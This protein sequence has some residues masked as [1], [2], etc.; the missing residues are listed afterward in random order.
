LDY[1]AAMVD[2]QKGLKKEYTYDGVHPNETGYKIMA[3]L[4]EQAIANTLDYAA[5]KK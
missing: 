1:Y 4:A 2:D 3:T 5:L